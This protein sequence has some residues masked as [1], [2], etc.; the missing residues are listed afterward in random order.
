MKTN[1]LREDEV[2]LLKARVER[3][4]GQV[5]LVDLVLHVAQLVQK[6]EALAQLLELRG[7]L[8]A[9]CIRGGVGWRLGGTSTSTSTRSTHDG[10]GH[11]EPR[12]HPLAE[13]ALGGQQRLHTRDASARRTTDG[14]P[15]LRGDIQTIGAAPC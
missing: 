5:A 9:G 6:A 11:L 8:S 14:Q 12:V 1:L 10:R 15:K 13:L 7:S 3:L 4:D 2:K